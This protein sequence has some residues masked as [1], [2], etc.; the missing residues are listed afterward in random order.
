M[1]PS[2]L[3][4][5]AVVFKSRPAGEPSRENFELIT[6]PVR[7]LLRDEL[8]IRT[9]FTSVDPAM[10]IRMRE[11][12]SYLPALELGQVAGTYSVGEVILSTNDAFRSGDV[13]WSFSGWQKYPVVPASLAWK[14]DVS[15]MSP[16]VYIGVLGLTGFT[17]YVGLVDIIKPQ[18]GETLVISAASGAV[19]SIAGQLA[20]ASGARVV[21]ITS[22]AE[23]CSFLR[24]LGFHETVDR[25]SG[26]LNRQ[27]DAACPKGID[28]FFDNTGGQIQLSVFDRLNL[29]SRVALC[30]QIAEY[31]DG[32]PTPG[33]N[34]WI[35]ISRRVLL[36][37]FI[38]GDELP[39]L[40][41]YHRY[42]TPLVLSGELSASETVI[43]GLENAPD[44]FAALL[45]GDKLGKVI[46]K[47]G[48]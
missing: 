34:L 35:A 4:D 7:E 32:N 41:T 45:R 20:R 19:G 21:G 33:P 18:H 24:K 9:L 37:G 12:A 31:N 40:G 26:D 39:R 5:T 25:T 27:L 15:N 13:V 16:S 8:L 23:R 28:G 1:Q 6:S 42:A 2:Q 38:A 44:A 46:V 47:V 30:G 17:A 48:G 43:N 36:K 3:I 29:N 10:R 22:G 14:V 11:G